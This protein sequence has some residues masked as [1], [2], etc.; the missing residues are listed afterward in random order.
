MSTRIAEPPI[1]VHALEAPSDE[2]TEITLVPVGRLRRRGLRAPVWLRGRAS[3]WIW[4]GVAIAAAGFV[5]LAIAW[6][7]VAGET[8]VYLQI[9]YLVS[10]AFVGV[11]VI[12]VGVTALV[13]A[14]KEQDTAAHRREVDELL[15]AIDELRRSLTET[16]RGAR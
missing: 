4:I 10:A 6:G 1:E 8:E 11:G 16:R 14:T 12:M 5:L 7:Q 15:G 2:P 13:V 3:S 9:P